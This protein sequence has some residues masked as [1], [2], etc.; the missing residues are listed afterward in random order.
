MTRTLSFVFPFWGVSRSHSTNA[1]W[2]YVLRSLLGRVHT[3]RVFRALL[4]NTRAGTLVML[5]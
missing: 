2:T 3:F 5:P 1:L 4:H